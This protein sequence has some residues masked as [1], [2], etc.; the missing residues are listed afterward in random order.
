M[1]LTDKKIEK[2]KPKGKLYRLVDMNG[3]EVRIHPK[4]GKY[5]IHRYYYEKKRL[6][7]NL[8]SYPTLSLK[9]ARQIHSNNRLMISRGINP[10]ELK[11]SEKKARKV[12][13]LNTFQSVAEK[14]F[15]EVFKLN[16]TQ[17]TWKK[18]I[19]YFPND[20]YP[21][22]GKKPINDI[23]ALEI[24][25]ACRKISDRGA[26]E[27]AIRVCR[28]ISDIFQWATLLGLAKSNVAYGLARTLPKHIKGNYTATTNPK[29]F[30]EILKK[31]DIF[32]GANTIIHTC[33]QIIPL[34][35]SRQGELRGMRWDELNLS[36]SEWTYQVSKTK[37]QH[38]VPLSKQVTILIKKLIPLTGVT[39]YVFAS[40]VGRGNEYISDS[41]LRNYLRQSGVTKDQ[42]DLH[43]FR[44]SART[45]ADEVLEVNTDVLEIQLSHKNPKDKHGGAYARAEFIK[46]RKEFMQQ[47]SDYCDELKNG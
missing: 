28:K 43:G 16:T 19:P 17:S 25:E 7:F 3:L 40:D 15:E 24:Y 11:A 46:Q 35:F 29:D 22:I 38:L 41:A 21:K 10:K 8:G 2:A 44:T 33:L 39:P 4:G 14:H 23:A 26:K 1:A 13:L 42:T 20:I 5:W 12:E 31:I 30:G 9:E 18:I 32:N 37:T 6:E 36:K 27:N 34:V 47:W 45:I